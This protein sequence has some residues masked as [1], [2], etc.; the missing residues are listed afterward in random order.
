M[1]SL[2]D[3]PLLAIEPALGDV[4]PRYEAVCKAVE[5]AGDRIVRVGHSQVFGP[6][7]VSLHESQYALDLR[8]YDWPKDAPG[9][10]RRTGYAWMMLRGDD[11]PW[12][13]IADFFVNDGLRGQG[14]G[15]V[16]MGAVK[17]IAARHGAAFVEGDLPS[18]D[19]VSRMQRFFVRQGFEAEVFQEQRGVYVG[20]VRWDVRADL[21]ADRP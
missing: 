21:A 11:Q 15:A 10:H 5:Q 19:D 13:H 17:E 2:M 3:R 12:L 16:L 4:R 6:W 7:V 1:I 14:R 20:R 9:R 18:T 8:L